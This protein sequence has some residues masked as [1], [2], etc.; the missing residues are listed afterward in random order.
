[1]L[2]VSLEYAPYAS[3]WFA[4]AGLGVAILLLWKRDDFLKVW[5]SVCSVSLITQY[6]Q[7]DSPG[8]I[9]NLSVSSAVAS[10][11]TLHEQSN[12]TIRYLLT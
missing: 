3:L 2:L 11:F 9:H 1:M 6:T 8:I 10:G 4:P 12:L 7:F 5:I